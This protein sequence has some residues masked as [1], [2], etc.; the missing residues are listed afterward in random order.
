MVAANRRVRKHVKPADN[1]PRRPGTR[2]ASKVRSVVLRM[3]TD[4][5]AELD[6]LCKINKRSRRVIVETLVREAADEL[7]GDAA[8]RINP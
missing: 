4:F 7:K 3:G 6:R 1:T 2:P 8:A 5:I